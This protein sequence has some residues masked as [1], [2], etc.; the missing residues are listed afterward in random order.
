MVYIIKIKKKTNEGGETVELIKAQELGYRGE[1]EHI[2]EGLSFSLSSG[3][4]L[5]VLGRSGSGKTTL[6]KLLNGLLTP[7]SGSLLVAG[8][9]ANRSESEWEIKRHCSLVF[10]NPDDQFVSSYLEEDLAFGPSSLGFDREETAAAVR[11]ALAQVGLSGYE[12]RSP[13]LL[14]SHQK[15]RAALAGALACKTEV[16]VLDELT[17]GLSLYEHMGLMSLCRKL[18]DQGRGVVLLSS[19][20]EEAAAADKLLL[21]SE[22]R[23]LAFGRAEDVL[24]NRELMEKA[25]FEAGFSQRVYD[26]LL[27]AGVRLD[28]LPITMEELVEEICR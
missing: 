9:D 12:R 21:L 7:G 28:N 25:G 6:A 17:A 10:Q 8:F 16:L 1:G 19:D 5:A 22:G 20:P 26:D 14:P 18:C 13:Q 27:E 2:L 11:L 23:A 15:R 24:S 4:M 3:E